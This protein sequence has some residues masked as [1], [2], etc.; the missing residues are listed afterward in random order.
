[1]KEEK[2]RLKQKYRNK[3]NAAN[4]TRYEKQQEVCNR[5]MNVDRN[6]LTTEFRI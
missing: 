4:K 2:T 1:V 6:A 3:K 5:N